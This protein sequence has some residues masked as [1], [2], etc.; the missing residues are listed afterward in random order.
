VSIGSVD[1]E[2]VQK[3]QNFSVGRCLVMSAVLLRAFEARRSPAIQ[4]TAV[5]AGCSAD[6]S[7]VCANDFRQQRICPQ[8]YPQKHHLGLQDCVLP[9]LPREVIPGRKQ[10]LQ[11]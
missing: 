11:E 3:N 9:R 4:K 7:F 10:P 1:S 2:R 8:A 5:D 6:F